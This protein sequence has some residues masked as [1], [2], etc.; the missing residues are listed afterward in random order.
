MS[1]FLRDSF[2]V[3]CFPMH[4]QSKLSSEGYRTRDGH[5]IEWLAKLNTTKPV[6]VISRPE[7]APLAVRKNK[8]V[9]ANTVDISTRSWQVP[10]LRNR[11]RWWVKSASSYPSLANVD[12]TLPAV[13]WNPFVALAP[14][15]SNPFQG[16][17]RVVFDLLDDWTVHFAFADIRDEVLE[18]YEAAFA[19]ADVVTANAEGTLE[20]AHR[21]GR[22]DAILLPNGVDPDRFSHR[23]E[24]TGP[25]NVGYV[26]K[27]G[28]RVDLDCIVKTAQANPAVTFTFAGPILDEEYRAPLRSL[29]NLKL[30]GD[31]HYLEVPRLLQTFDIGWVPHRVGE[32]EVGGDVIK[33]YEYRAAGLPVLATPFAGVMERGFAELFVLDAQQH[34]QWI[35]DI[36][37]RSTR[38]PRVEENIPEPMTWESK[39]GRIKEFYLAQ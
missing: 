3:L 33:T 19:K 22:D 26:G 30:L 24:P 6:A 14:D 35:A 34:P 31:V 16:K 10:D 21:F 37:S 15:V 8:N 4:G 36:A 38:V 29:P 7:P 27:I 17:R 11:R 12:P 28:K 13:A 32:G 25:L 18:A 39:A 1:R 5:I 9:A 23:E 20:L 2:S